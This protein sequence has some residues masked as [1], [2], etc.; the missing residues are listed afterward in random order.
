MHA[1]TL[2]FL[3]AS[4]LATEPVVQVLNGSYAG[5]HLPEYHQDI[6]LGIPYAQGMIAVPKASP[7][8]RSSL[9]TGGKNRFR[10]PQPLEESWDGVRPATNYSHACPDYQPEDTVHGMSENCLSIN[11]VRP[12]GLESDA[13]FPVLLWIHGGS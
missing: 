9:D 3:I 7:I 12:T 1:I 4:V 8:L 2:F 11:V 5:I 6:F 10:V 13:R